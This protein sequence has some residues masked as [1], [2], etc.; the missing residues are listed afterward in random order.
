MRA[1]HALLIL[2]SLS[3]LTALDVPRELTV[4]QKGEPASR[5]LA[6]WDQTRPILIEDAGQPLSDSAS[7]ARGA[8]LAQAWTALN[9]SLANTD[10]AGATHAVLKLIE[11]LYGRPESQP[12]RR[13]S[14]R[15]DT[16]RNFAQRLQN[17]DG[18]LRR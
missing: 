15:N 1:V 17:V 13:M 11:D 7:L 8:P 4:P 6:L 9:D 10:E 2:V 18:R 16:R 14:I 3:F 12:D 5:V